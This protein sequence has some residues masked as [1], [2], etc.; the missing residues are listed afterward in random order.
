MPEDGSP[1]DVLGREV[2][3]QCDI[4]G[5]SQ[6]RRMGYK[7]FVIHMSN[8]QGGLEEIMDSEKF[9]QFVGKFGT[10]FHQKMAFQVPINWEKYSKFFIFIIIFC[11]ISFSF[12]FENE[13]RTILPR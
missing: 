8:D 10:Y 11:Y 13:D 4:K 7:V 5:C 1:R 9:K 3:Y 2:K 6:K 12:S